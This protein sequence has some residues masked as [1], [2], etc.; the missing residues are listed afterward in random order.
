MKDHKIRI[1]NYLTTTCG[2]S[3][4]ELCRYLGVTK[5]TISRQLQFCNDWVVRF[6]AARSCRYYAVRRILRNEYQWPIYRIT[7]TGTMEEGGRLTSIHP[8]HWH[9]E[10]SKNLC[11]FN[12]GEFK[13]GVYPGLPWFLE[14]MRPQGFLG[15]LFV[16]QYASSLRIGTDASLWKPEDLLH[17]LLAHGVDCPGNLIIGEEVA[18]KFQH[19]R[20]EQ[21]NFRQLKDRCDLYPQLADQALRGTSVGSSAGGEQQKFTTTLENN[22]EIKHV[23][24]KFSPPIN[25]PSGRRWADLLLCEQLALEILME[26]NIPAAS[27]E[28]IEAEGRIFLESAR[29]DRCGQHGRRGVYSCIHFDAA[30][31]GELDDWHFFAD[32]LDADQWVPPSDTKTL[33][34]LYAFGTMI[35]NTDM[36]FGNI[37]LL[38]EGN[39][40]LRLA[41]CYDMLPML[42][43]PQKTGEILTKKFL[44]AAPSPSGH[45]SWKQAFPYALKFWEKVQTHPLIDPSFKEMV[46]DNSIH[47]SEIMKSL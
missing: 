23:I 40:S 4:E 22:T 39:G 18:K 2:A 1:K 37:S 25:T 13:Q 14:N 8:S 11:L 42:Y 43:A 34:L 5:A 27:T 28:I 45:E 36:H 30:Y 38:Q 17:A 20:L 26:G 21:I 41:P 16:N 24:V 46:R 7:E 47:I 33:R 31:Y 6:G 29:F 9:F 3:A 15:R 44:I 35:G 19:Q 10:A 32:R 12:K